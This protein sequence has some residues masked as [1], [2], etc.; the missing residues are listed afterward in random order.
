MDLSGYDAYLDG[1][2]KDVELDE[3]VLKQSLDS[4]KG[5]PVPPPLW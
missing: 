4:M 3:K 2:L 1:K 5:L